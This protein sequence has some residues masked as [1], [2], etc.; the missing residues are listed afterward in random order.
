MA[1]ILL[2]EDNAAAAALICQYMKALYSDHQIT[3]CATATDA[4]D[5]AGKHHIDLFILDIQ[6]PDYR[7]TELGKYIR[8][9]PEYRF[10]PILFTTELG[11]EELA[12]YREIKCY[13]FLIKPFTQEQ[14]LRA[15]ST[16]LDMGQQMKKPESILRIEQKQFLFEYE[17]KQIRYIESFGK[18]LVIHSISQ[19]EDLADQI[20]GYSLMRLLEL[21]GKDNLIQCHKSF[22]INPV[23]IKK[24]D[25]GAKELWLKDCKETIPIGEKYQHNLRERAL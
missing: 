9:M 16:A 11:G 17:L 20:S 22:L 24:I 18:R 8:A 13:D 6:L 2:V 14:F 21:A 1:Q 19:G 23:F 3:I 25:K 5:W 12:A 7:G 15:V 4:F 10:T